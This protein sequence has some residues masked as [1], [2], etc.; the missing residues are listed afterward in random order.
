MQINLS[1]ETIKTVWKTLK[2]RKDDLESILIKFECGSPSTEIEKD[3]KIMLA[4][5]DEALRVFDEV[6]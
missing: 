6:I 1:Y 3:F 2:F 4:E 5:L